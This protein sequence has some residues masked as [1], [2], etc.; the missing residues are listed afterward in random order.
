MGVREF[1]SL[2]ERKK[3]FKGIKIRE[4]TSTATFNLGRVLGGDKMKIEL[5]KG[6]LKITPQK[7]EE[8]GLKRWLRW[9]R[10]YKG[11]DIPFAAFVKLLKYCPYKKEIK[12]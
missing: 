12:K 7:G 3:S 6:I 5:I 11:P 10:R 9:I 8:E 1:M 4:T 2:M